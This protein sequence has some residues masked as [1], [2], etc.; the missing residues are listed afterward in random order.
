MSMITAPYLKEK[1][2]EYA[3]RHSF[4]LMAKE[5]KFGQMVRLIKENGLMEMLKEKEPLHI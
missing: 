3:R 4:N 5:R 1:W 2:Q